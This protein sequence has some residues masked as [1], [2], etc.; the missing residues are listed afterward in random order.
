MQMVS[1][2]VDRKALRSVRIVVRDVEA[3]GEDATT[4]A[5]VTMTSQ[6]RVTLQRSSLQHCHPERSRRICKNESKWEKIN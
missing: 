6:R 3:I 4:V 1:R 2:R 5:A